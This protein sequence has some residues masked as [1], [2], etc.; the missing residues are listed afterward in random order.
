VLVA[1]LLYIIVFVVSRVVVVVPRAV[2][3]NITG[4][5]VATPDGDGSEAR[6]LFCKPV[7]A[8]AELC[9]LVGKPVNIVPFMMVATVF[10]SREVAT[11]MLRVPDANIRAEYFCATVNVIT[12]DLVEVT[13]VYMVSEKPLVVPFGKSGV[14]F[15]LDGPRVTF[16]GIGSIVAELLAAEAGMKELTLARPGTYGA[17]NEVLA[18][19][20]KGGDTADESMLVLVAVANRIDAIV[21]PV[22]VEG[23]ATA[24]VVELGNVQ[25]PEVIEELAEALV[26]RAKVV[27]AFVAL[28]SVVE[29]L[30][31]T[32]VY[33]RTVYLSVVVLLA[34]AL[35]DN[36]PS[37]VARITIV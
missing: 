11:D 28:V 14:E 24:I 35:T 20:A 3:S 19:V 23:F 16:P 1:T 10:G 30:V 8:E 17:A 33:E 2:V 21:I 32:V 4:G 27:V 34:L 25:T 26:A 7:A 6:K 29:L 37:I 12:K 22:L 13:V 18:V 36:R 9:G 15:W 5:I 31:M